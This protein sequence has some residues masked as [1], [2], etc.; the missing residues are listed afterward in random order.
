MYIITD[1]N[2]IKLLFNNNYE[3]PSFSLTNLDINNK[4]INIVYIN[5]IK[6]MFSIYIK[7][8]PNLIEIEKKNYDTNLEINNIVS[9][10]NNI[11]L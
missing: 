4:D 8:L 11:I 5:F 7:I 6:Y 10:I 1:K 9:L 2:K 3:I